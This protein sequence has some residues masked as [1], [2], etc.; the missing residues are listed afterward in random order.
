[1]IKEN[2]LAA[3]ANDAVFVERSSGTRIEGNTIEGEIS[4]IEAQRVVEPIAVPAHRVVHGG[5]VPP[6][7]LPRPGSSGISCAV[8]STS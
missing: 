1:M 7:P 8:P 2:F 3:Q 4:E 6:V 5:S